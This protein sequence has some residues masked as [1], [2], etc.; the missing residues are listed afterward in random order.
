MNPRMSGIAD[1]ARGVDRDRQRVERDH[2]ALEA[3]LFGR[4]EVEVVDPE[5]TGLR[6]QRVVDIGDVADARD[7][8]ALVDQ[9]PLQHVV[10][11]ERRRVAEVGGVVRRDP[12]GV[13]QH[14][15]VR[16]ERHDGAARGVVELQR[17]AQAPTAR[18]STLIPV[19][20]GA[21]RVL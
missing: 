8:V 15:L 1:E 16:F 9:V 13:H 18:G 5:L 10:G 7:R 21:T 19:S 4:G 3:R 2:V 20:F 14:V 17:H 6:E 12:A 11:D